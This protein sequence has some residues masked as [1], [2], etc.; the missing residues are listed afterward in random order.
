MASRMNQEPRARRKMYCKR[1]RRPLLLM[2]WIGRMWLLANRG[3]IDDDS[4]VT[5]STEPASYFVAVAATVAVLASI[6]RSSSAIARSSIS[7]TCC[8]SGLSQ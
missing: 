8:P 3:E 6:E 5:A 4:I 2:C 7:F 1:N